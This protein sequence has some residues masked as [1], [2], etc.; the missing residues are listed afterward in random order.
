MAQFVP[1]INAS[2]LTI[3]VRLWGGEGGGGGCAEDRV[4]QV[5]EPGDQD[6]AN[7]MRYHR[8]FSCEPVWPL[9]YHAAR[10]VSR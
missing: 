9:W 5:S 3:S 4:S 1:L 6:L 10:R 7:C 2:T 8:I